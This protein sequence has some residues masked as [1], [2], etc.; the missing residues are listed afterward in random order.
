MYFVYIKNFFFFYCFGW[1]IKASLYSV[2]L[3]D[4]ICIFEMIKVGIIK[5]QKDCIRWQ[6]MLLI[7]AGIYLFNSYRIVVFFDISYLLLEVV[8]LNAFNCGVS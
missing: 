4:W 1:S 6:V 8:K 3:E 7:V 2:F 5:R